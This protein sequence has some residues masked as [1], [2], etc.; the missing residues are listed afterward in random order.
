MTLDSKLPFHGS[1]PWGIWGNFESE[2]GGLKPLAV[3][4]PWIYTETMTTTLQAWGNSQ[5]VR[6][7]KALLA[8]LHLKKGMRLE[9]DLSP[10]KDAIIVK[11]AGDAVSPR[12]KHRIEDLVSKMPRNYKA[13]EFSAMRVVARSGK[14]LPIFH[15]R[16]IW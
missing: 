7:P 2:S 3:C 8:A 1:S 5:G 11:P 14:W 13:K 16:E 4:I 6:I 12:G 9:L 15:A 10:K